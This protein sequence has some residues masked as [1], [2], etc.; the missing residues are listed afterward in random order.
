MH[1]VT[2]SYSRSRDEDSGHVI[3]SV[4]DEKTICCTQTSPLCVLQKRSY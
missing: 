2:R 4:V 3:R 1:L